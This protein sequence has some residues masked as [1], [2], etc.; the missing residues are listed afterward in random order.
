M[1]CALILANL[2][3]EGPM[4]AYVAM[5]D[6]NCTIEASIEHPADRIRN[7]TGRRLDHKW[8]GSVGDYRQAESSDLRNGYFRGALVRM[9]SDA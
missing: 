2:R 4:P 1:R 7:A 3:R 9:K 5:T 8:V 6:T